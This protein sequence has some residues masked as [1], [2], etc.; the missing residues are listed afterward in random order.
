[1]GCLRN[2]ISWKT[3]SSQAKNS[4]IQRFFFGVIETDLS[5][6]ASKAG[7]K[8][9]MRSFRYLP[10]M[11]LKQ[12]RDCILPSRFF[13]LLDLLAKGPPFSMAPGEGAAWSESE[14]LVTAGCWLEVLSGWS[15]FE[16]EILSREVSRLKASR[17]I[18]SEPRLW[19][20]FGTISAVSESVQN[21]AH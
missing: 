4:W 12:R 8:F 7:L 20:R 14:R 13:V 15:G 17:R 5:I 1:M 9:H 19:L 18:N 6:K 3:S 2:T 16:P 21:V 11:L 10:S